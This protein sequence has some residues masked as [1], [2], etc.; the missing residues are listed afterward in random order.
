MTKEECSTLIQEEIMN[1]LDATYDRIL[2]E[3]QFVGAPLA[4]ITVSAKDLCQ[5]VVDNFEKLDDL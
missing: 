2:R 4:S 1:Y 5:I 3:Y